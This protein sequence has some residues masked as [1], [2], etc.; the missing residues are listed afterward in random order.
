MTSMSVEVEQRENILDRIFNL[1]V[2]IKVETILCFLIILVAVITRFYDLESR[3]MSHDESLHTYY[4]WRYLKYQDY[5]HLPMMHGPLQ[6]HL[7]AF[8]YF[9]FGDSDA[10]SRYPYALAGV[11]S[12]ALI[13][14]FRKWLGRWG[15]LIAMALMLVSPYMLYYQRYVRNEALVVFEALLMFWAIFSYFE[16]RQSKWL[17]LLSA[18]LVLHF[19]TKET[20]FIYALELMLFLGVFLAWDILR[21]QWKSQ[22]NKIIFI[23]GLAGV[24]VG[25]LIMGIGFFGGQAGGIQDPNLHVQPL[26]PTATSTIVQ[27]SNLTG[28]FNFGVFIAVLSAVLMLIILARSFGKQ[29][30]TE[31]PALDLLVI[32]ITM[33]LPQLAGIPAMILN[34]DPLPSNTSVFKTQTGI[35]VVILI[36]LSLAIGLLW[37]WRRWIIAAAIFYGPFIA[38]YTSLFRNGHGLSSGLVSSLEYWITQHGEERGSQPWFYYILIQLPIYE[39][40]PMLGSLVAAGF[41]IKALFKRSSESTERDSYSNKPASKSRGS[42]VVPKLQTF[43]VPIFF[44]YWGIISL[45]A[46]SFAGERMPWLTV[47]I[48]LPFILLAGWAI[49]KWVESTNWEDLRSGRGWASLALLFITYFA[50]EKALGILLGPAPPFQGSE[51]DSLNETTAFLS[52]MAI[53][54]GSVVALYFVMKNLEFKRLVPLGLLV[55]FAITFVLTIRA[56]FRAAYRNYDQA[57]EFLVYAH[58]ATGVKTV[59]SQV[60]EYSIRTSGDLAVEV[61]YDDDVSWPFTWYFRNYTKKHYYGNSPSRD[62]SSYP[63]VIAGDNNWSQVDPILGRS[64]LTFEYIRMWWPMQEYFGLT[65]ARVKEAFTNRNIRAGIWDIWIDRDYTAYG[66]AT[67]KDFSLE[68]WSPVDKMKFYIRKDV[69]TTIWDYGVIAAAAPDLA[70]TDPYEEKMVDLS[71]DFIIGQSGSASGQL[72]SPRSIAVADDGSLYVADSKNHRIQY[73]DAEGNVLA[74]WGGYGD[75]TQGDPVPGKFNEPWGVA[76]APDGSVYVADTWNHRIQHFTADGEYLNS[77]GTFGQGYEGDIFW[78]PRAVAVDDQGRLFVVD[79][80]NKRVAVFDENGM[81]LDQLGGTEFGTGQLNEPVGIALDPQGWIYIADTWNQRV[82]VYEEIESGG[83][84]FVREWAIDGW[85]GQSLENKPYLSLSPQGNV[86]STDPEGYRILCFTPSGDFILGWGTFGVEFNAFGLPCGV[87]FTEDGYLWVSDAS[88][89]RLM[90]F[91]PG[92]Q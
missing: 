87:A 52:A 88:N 68:N 10:S 13:Y 76:V 5:E 18:S 82:V 3:V 9:L 55:L 28:L 90:R 1:G 45:F 34:L 39:F 6:F 54:I 73:F 14:V 57:T 64:F 21:R 38:L 61:A 59:L 33:T 37:D 58:S 81:F 30:R 23:I 83:F 72:S 71:A 42:K 66:Q 29:L 84:R 50:L 2:N 91:K 67:G 7:T 74:E 48:V 41:G 27:P 79:T 60:E 53:G 44:G 32:T 65:W 78:G 63:L 11:A 69:A 80:G 36:L 22:E 12:I 24:L 62:L 15:T 20:S 43:P 75:I 51:L 92:L 31:F 77:F 8:S 40:L 17:Y 49:G 47:H 56:A 35:I 16:T 4:S 46:Y 89:N 26:D 85:W 86:C 25:V 70:L 19:T